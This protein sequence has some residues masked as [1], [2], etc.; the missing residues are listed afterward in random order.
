M[1]GQDNVTQD[2]DSEHSNEI[3]GPTKWCTVNTGTKFVVPLKD[4][5]F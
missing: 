3:L 1:Y 5:N 2:R 4:V